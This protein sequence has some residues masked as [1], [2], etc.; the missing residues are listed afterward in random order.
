MRYETK[1][2]LFNSI[3]TSIPEKETLIARRNHFKGNRDE[4]MLPLL[5]NP[6]EYPIVQAFQKANDKFIGT[7]DC[8]LWST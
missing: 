6:L 3:I 4:K 7:R 1:K 8:R 5:R 2:Y